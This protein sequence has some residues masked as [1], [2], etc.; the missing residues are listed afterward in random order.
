MMMKTCCDVKKAVEYF[1]SAGNRETS[2][3]IKEDGN[4]RREVGCGVNINDQD[5]KLRGPRDFLKCKGG[6]GEVIYE[7][8]SGLP[9][10]C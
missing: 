1:D 8:Q 10:D 5:T 2:K 7:L 9:F 4:D 3:K 6:P